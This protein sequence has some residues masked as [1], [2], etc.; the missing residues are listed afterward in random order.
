M[1]LLTETEAKAV[2]SA[3]GQMTG[4]TMSQRQTLR[5]VERKIAN[6]P[7]ALTSDQKIGLLV[8]VWYLRAGLW[9]IKHLRESTVARAA[10]FI[11]ENF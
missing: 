2:L 11:R 8:C 3:I 9:R 5:R 1:V 6:A 4:R 10:E 7:A